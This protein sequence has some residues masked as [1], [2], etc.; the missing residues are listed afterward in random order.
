MKN[1]GMYVSLDIGT[2]SI[3]VVVAEF[4]N[5]EMNIIGVGNEKSE[6][7]SRGIIVDI[8][9]TVDSINK[10][11]KQAEQK[12]NVDINKVIVGIPANNIEIEPCQGM[13]AI[14][15]ENKEIVKEDVCNVLSA[16]M[17]K[18][19]PP[20]KEI[21]AIL[22]EEFIVDGF[23]GIKD[24]RG[25]IGV[26]LEMHATMITGPKTIIHNTKKCVEKAGLQIENI[27]LQPLAASSIAMSK[28]ESDFGTILIDMGGG[29][30]TASVMHDNQLKFAF[31]NQ[32]GG[33]YVTKDISVV[34]NTSFENAE[35][36]KRDY[37]YALPEDASPD[38]EFP[39]EIIGQSK[40]INV[41]EQ[42]LSEI[43]EARLVQIFGKIKNKLDFIEARDLPGGIILT[44]GAAAIPGVIG[45]AEDIFEAN[46]KLYIPDQMGMRYPTFTTSIGLV[47]YE[48]K[49][50]DIHQIIKDYSL[51]QDMPTEDD[52]TIR[53]KQSQILDYE[54]QEHHYN[55]KPKKQEKRKEDTLVFKAKSFFTNFFD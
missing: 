30:T 47:N 23:D 4:I 14:S 15:G 34:L 43:I 54:E 42:Y 21:L 27:V 38:E 53:Q 10:A 40:P 6:G 7:L 45:L 19:V 44:G 2:T 12:A 25:M 28:G 16:A 35:R 33:E 1:T 20:E 24:P 46:V 29:Q 36:I 31:V 13:I 50:D 41:D 26:R 32:E 3:K 51:N 8:D 18:S 11:I 55:E 9:K 37:G 48:A 39:V 17:V 5:G 49:L 52:N 22:P